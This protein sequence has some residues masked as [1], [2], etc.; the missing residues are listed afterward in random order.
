MGLVL[1]V[2]ALRTASPV[3]HHIGLAG[4]IFF[5][6]VNVLTS[7]FLL[8]FAA[9]LWNIGE[10]GQAVRVAVVTAMG[11]V[12]AA[13]YDFYSIPGDDENRTLFYIAALMT[14]GLQLI[15]YYYAYRAM[16]DH[17]QRTSATNFARG[18]VTADELT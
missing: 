12:I 6:V 10:R 2:Y 13:T 17:N 3:T 7:I 15:V 8:Y 9:R 16:H 18:P 5:I 4:A 11:A 1:T 14:W